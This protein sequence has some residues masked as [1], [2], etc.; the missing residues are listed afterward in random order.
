MQSEIDSQQ[1]LRG[2][3][4]LGVNAIGRESGNEGMTAGRVLPWLQPSTGEDVWT[5]WQV[6]YRDVV[7]LGPGNE[8]LGV[9]NLTENDL[10]DPANYA[11]LKSQLLDAAEQQY[12]PD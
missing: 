1:A 10:S 3:Q 11:A 5:L 9:F 7:I 2:V 8:R 12:E 4:I 6:T